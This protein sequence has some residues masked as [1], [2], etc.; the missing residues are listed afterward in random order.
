[1][2]K[3]SENNG[4]SWEDEESLEND[5]NLYVISGIRGKQSLENE[6]L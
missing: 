5:G 4:K 6:Q 1:M 3:S 2:G